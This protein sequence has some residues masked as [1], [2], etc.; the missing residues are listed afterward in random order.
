MCWL[1]V[2]SRA[3]DAFVAAGPRSE[4]GKKMMADERVYQMAGP[5][6]V[7][8]VADRA[9]VVY[10][11]LVFGPLAGRQLLTSPVSFQP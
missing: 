4:A 10:V 7:A 9:G 6:E 3:Y 1:A 2:D 8:R 11:E 5:V